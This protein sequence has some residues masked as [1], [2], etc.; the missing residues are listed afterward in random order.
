MNSFG[1][2]NFWLLN[3]ATPSGNLDFE[4]QYHYI[5]LIRSDHRK[6]CTVLINLGRLQAR[7][8][9]LV[10]TL[11]KNCSYKLPNKCYI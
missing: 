7:L 8:Q 2:M 1:L 5:T 6:I 11:F 4:L 10:K 3:G 9:L